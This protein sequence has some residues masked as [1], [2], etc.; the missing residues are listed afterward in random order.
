MKQTSLFELNVLSKT[1]EEALL[2]LIEKFEAT[3]KKYAGLL[4]YEDAYSELKLELIRVIRNIDL[5]KLRNIS[6]GTIVNYIHTAIKNKYICLS[7]AKNKYENHFI[8][9]NEL[10]DFE[11]LENPNSFE[12]DD[13]CVIDKDFLKKHLTENEYFVIIRFFYCNNKISEIMKETNKSRQAI[14]KTKLNAIR[15]LKLILE[16]NKHKKS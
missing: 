4:R 10:S 11:R 16:E 1:D 14:N 12:F 9:Y 2:V 7:K 3:L 15:K 5:T 8:L 6:D 13:Y